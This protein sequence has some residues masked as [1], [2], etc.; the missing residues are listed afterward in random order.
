MLEYYKEK[1]NQQVIIC[2]TFRKMASIADYLSFQQEPQG[3]IDLRLVMS[4]TINDSDGSKLELMMADK[5]IKLKYRLSVRRVNC[6]SSKLKRMPFGQ[7]QDKRG[8]IY[9]AGRFDGVEGLGDRLR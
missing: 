1:S 3:H 9:L 8:R 7:V 5:T 6:P 4:F 2:L